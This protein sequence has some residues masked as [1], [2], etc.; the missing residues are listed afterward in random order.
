MAELGILGCVADGAVDGVQHSPRTSGSTGYSLNILYSKMTVFTSH[1]FPTV[2][3]WSTI[4]VPL[5]ILS[6]FFY[7][8]FCHA[9]VK[10]GYPPHGVRVLFQ[11]LRTSSLPLS[12]DGLLRVGSVGELLAEVVAI[13]AGHVRLILAINRN[14]QQYQGQYL[15][16]TVETVQGKR[17]YLE[18]QNL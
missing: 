14:G 10:A 2:I 5:P 12:P 6:Y 11:R 8:I 15:G 18:E 13:A 4:G 9:Q 1:S 17:Q 7:S 3:E 16:R